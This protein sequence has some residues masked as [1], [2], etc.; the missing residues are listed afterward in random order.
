MS[1]WWTGIEGTVR[2]PRGPKKQAEAFP[3]SQRPIKTPE[4]PTITQRSG[5]ELRV[6]RSSRRDRSRRRISPAQFCRHIH[7]PLATDE[8]CISGKEGRVDVPAHRHLR[9]IKNISSSQS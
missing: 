4:D 6:P 7:L 1:C 9:P 3:T 5:T 2:G 8:E